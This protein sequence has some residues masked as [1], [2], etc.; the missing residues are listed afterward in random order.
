MGMRLA[1][2]DS[3]ARQ[4]RRHDCGCACSSLLGIPGSQGQAPHFNQQMTYRLCWLIE[5]VTLTGL[6]GA[7]IAGQMLFL[8]VPG[9]VSPVEMST[10]ICRLSRE[11]GPPQR[12]WATSN[13]LRLRIEQK[14]GGRRNLLSLLKQDT[15]LLLPLDM[16][17]LGSQAIRLRLGLRPS[18]L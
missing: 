10:G 9:R 6:R 11:D 4:A 13:P 18:D 3:Q 5:C 14:G 8:G 7:T 17:A 1:A 12:G 16:G 2:S 15:H